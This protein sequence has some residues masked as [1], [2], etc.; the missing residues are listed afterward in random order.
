MT[1]S[2]FLKNGRPRGLLLVLLWVV[3][4]RGG[5]VLGGTSGKEVG[6]R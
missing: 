6:G 3:C 4:R 1:C 5:M 2:L